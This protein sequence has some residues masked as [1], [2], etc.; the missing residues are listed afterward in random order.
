MCNCITEM[1]KKVAEAIQK[2]NPDLEVS[3]VE[4]QNKGL[5]FTKHDSVRVTL[6]LEGKINVKTKSGA[7]KVKKV[8][9]AMVL[10]KCPFCGVGYNNE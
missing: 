2:Q 10:S 3:D 7:I 4:L 9:Q 1:E 6:E 8:K 5:I